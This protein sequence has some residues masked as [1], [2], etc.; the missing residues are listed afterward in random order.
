MTMAK[1]RP[2]EGGSLRPEIAESWRRAAGAGLLPG[3]TIE[4]V[5]IADVDRTSR[6]MVA[7][8]P[9]LDEL[10]VNLEDTSHCLML[11]DRDCI[12]VDTRFTDHRVVAAIEKIGAVPGSTYSEEVS[13]TNSIATPYKTQRGL[14]V[15]GQEHFLE[16]LK[17][18]SCYGL[19]IRHPLTR[20]IEGVLDVTGVMPRANPLFVPLVKRAVGD[21]EQRLLEGAR[22]SEQ[23]LLSAFKYAEKLSSR[24]VVV[25][26]EGL[27]LTNPAAVDLLGADDHVLLRAMAADVPDTGTLERRLSLAS[28]RV[29]DLVASRIS[30]ALGAIFQFSSAP[31]YAE[32]PRPRPPAEASGAELPLTRGRELTRALTPWEQAEYDAIVAALRATAG[33]KLQAAERLGISRSTLYNRIRAFRITL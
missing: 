29:V 26:G 28:G 13:G 24:A 8:R 6:L 7:A 27:V 17:K 19:P 9:V 30:G 20:R 32:T 4:R 16:S 18:F 21:I 10:A 33:N 3:M 31:R 22:R 1:S 15:H 2:A 23:M 5:R 11:A 25:L 14:L 12:I